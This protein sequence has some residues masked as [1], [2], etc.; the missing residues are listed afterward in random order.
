MSRKTFKKIKS[1]ILE[2]GLSV[3]KVAVRSGSSIAISQLSGLINGENHP[4][5]F[6]RVLT[7]Q[8]KVL[9]KE[10]SKLKGSLMKMGQM[11]A[12]YGEYFFPDEVVEVLKELNDDSATLEWGEIEKVIN[13]SLTLEKIKKLQ[14]E[15]EAFAAASIG[16]VHR[17][18]IKRGGDQVWPSSSEKIT[19]EFLRREFSRSSAANWRPSGD[20]RTPGSH[21]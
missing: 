11:L 18:K 8:A 21:R 9:T 1:G 15:T 19:K 2:R 16:Q 20:R 7:A 14:I 10:L 4:D 6:K 13:R 5:D 17:A 12:L 3:T